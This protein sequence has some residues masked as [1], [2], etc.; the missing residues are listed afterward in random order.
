MSAATLT[1]R[2]PLPQRLLAWAG[3]RFPLA[4][5]VLALSMYATA[6]VSGRALTH[7]GRLWVSVSDC[8]AFFGVWSYFLMLR[9]FDEHKDFDRDCATHP[10]RVL[11]RGVVTLGHLKVVGAIA[12]ALQ[13]GASLLQDGGLGPVTAW[14]AIAF[15]WS[16]LM[17][18]EFFVGAWLERRLVLY[19]TSHL[20]S[21]PLAALWMAQMG[22]GDGRL[23]GQVLWLALAAFLLGGAF[24]VGRKLKAPE[25]ERPDVDSYTKTLGVRGAATALAV[26]LAACAAALSALLV[27]TDAATAISLSA[28]TVAALGAVAMTRSFARNPTRAT[29]ARTEAVVA[30]TLLAQLV[31]VTLVLVAQRGL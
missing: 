12:I 16:L 5:G 22:A 28:L 13:L 26:T 20:V 6:L 29:A 24:E 15:G 3:E 31:T 8:L 2:A 18:K 21:L 4:N 1:S 27:V 9:V 19:A 10:D 25:D 7:Q 17:L 23:P 30:V 11:Q 14:W